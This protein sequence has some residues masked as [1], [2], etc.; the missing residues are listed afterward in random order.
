M[1][2]YASTA[3]NWAGL[4]TV[5]YDSLAKVFI[6]SKSP[7][8]LF[9]TAKNPTLHPPAPHHLLSPPLIKVLSG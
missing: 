7:E 9:G 6:F 5:E 3:A 4:L 2:L 1:P 8:S